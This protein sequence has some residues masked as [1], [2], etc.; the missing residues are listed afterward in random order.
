MEG[1]LMKSRMKQNLTVKGGVEDATKH[2]DTREPGSCR[3]LRASRLTCARANWVRP[4]ARPR[5]GHEAGLS[6]GDGRLRCVRLRVPQRPGTHR[7]GRIEGQDDRARQRRVAGNL[8][9]EFASNGIDPSSIK[10]VEAANSWGQVLVQGKADAALSW[11]GLR[12]QW[13]GQGLEFDYLVAQLLETAGQ[14]LRYASR[15]FRG[16]VEKGTPTRSTSAAGRWVSSSGISTSVP[17]RRSRCSSSPLEL[18]R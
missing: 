13:K 12:A 3:R 9:S 6:L 4:L 1:G 5:A 2:Y 17:Q 7:S 11:E 14:H 10:Y 8:R 18:R 15:G 16:C